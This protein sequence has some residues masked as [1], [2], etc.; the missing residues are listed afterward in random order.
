MSFKIIL[1]F[2]AALGIVDLLLGNRLKIGKEFEKGIMSMGTLVLAMVGM[3]VISPTVAKVFVTVFEPVTDFLHMDISVL[4]GIFPCDAG[5]A[6]MAFEMSENE[7]MAGYNGIIV[8]SMLG[9]TISFIPIALKVTNKKFHS[10]VFIGLLFGIATMPLGC[11]AGGLVIGCPFVPL[12]LNSIPTIFISV[13]TCVGLATNPVLTQKIFK[14]IG[15]VLIFI[16][17]IGL[18]I[19]I[20]EYL[21]GIKLL[22]F[23]MPLEEGFAVIA[24]IAIMLCGIFPL[25][26]IISNVFRKF[27]K[28]LGECIGIDESSVVGLLT[29]M[30]NCVPMFA[31]SGEMNQ[32]GRIMN[33]AFTVSV[34]CVFGDHLAFTMVF[35]N[36]QNL[37]TKYLL[38]LIVGKLAG[39]IAALT[40]A[41]FLYGRF[42]KEHTEN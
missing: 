8:G 41:N 23:T 38:G 11:I 35:A 34:S 3:M 30:A 22:P 39:G 15:N 36:A 14:V 5:G 28:L 42:V 25:I 18:G 32:K 40:V 13:I 4:S 21:G 6:K 31:K 33:Y 10:D 24:D 2:F 7:L 1:A 27:F 29:T 9:C 19:G 37:G 12:L 16:V 20:L 17:Y 26:A